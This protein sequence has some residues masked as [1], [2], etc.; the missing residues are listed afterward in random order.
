MSNRLSTVTRRYL[1]GIV[2]N[3]TQ[4]H[5][6]EIRREIVFQKY[7]QTIERRDYK[8]PDGRIDEYYIH[9]ARP[10]AC[11]L[12]LTP[13]KKVVTIPQYRPGPDKVLHELPGGFIDEHESPREAAV[14]ELLEETGYSGQVE[15]W[16]GTWWVDAYAETK[17]TIVIV[18]DCQ[19]AAQ[20]Q[21][22]ANEFGEVE[23]VE[24]AD[25]VTQARAGELT[26]AGGAMLALDHL[27]F[28]R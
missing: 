1:E 17:N 25:F 26:D 9:V 18:T 10:G 4:K 14:R 22:G 6:Q 21:L 15:S 16:T 19:L 3:M 28:L 24:L 7:S 23:L 11:A 27:G 2:H 13:D 12:A 20:P 5:W 8:L